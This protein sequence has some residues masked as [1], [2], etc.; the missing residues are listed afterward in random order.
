MVAPAEP[1]L[2]G[3]APDMGSVRPPKAKAKTGGKLNSVEIIQRSA[4]QEMGGQGDVNQIVNGISVLVQMGKMQLLQLGNTV[5]TI[6]PKGGGIAEIHIF[7]V[8]KPEELVK[9]FKSAAKAIKNMGFRQVVT[10]AESPA[11]VKM[12]QQT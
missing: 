1:T 9:Q 8:D 3:K 10:Y 11:F 6:M 7:T 12:A 5:F 4:Q 2:K